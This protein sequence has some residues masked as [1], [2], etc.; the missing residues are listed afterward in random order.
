[1]IGRSNNGQPKSNGQPKRKVRY[2]VVGL[3]YFGQMAILPAFEHARKNSELAALISDDPAKLKR[4]GAKYG[5]EQ[6]GGY[7]EFE[8]CLQRAKVDAVYLAV[9]NSQHREFAVRA[10]RA[11]VHV[12]CEKPMAVTERECEE[13]I[14]ACERNRVKLMIG[15]RLHFE[16]GNLTA[17][18]LVRSGKLGDPRIFNS[19]FT[20]QVKD[21]HNIR[22]RRETGGGSVYDIGI[23]CINAAR[24]LFADEPVEVAAMTA[25][26]GEARF[27]EV[28]EMA[29]VLM[30][31]PN[32][33]LAN[34]V[35]SFGGAD[36]GSYEIVGTD[37]TLRM[38]PAYESA[39]D[40][41]Q[42]VTIKGR[43][44]ERTFPKRDQVAPE[45]IYFSDCI[46]NDQEPEPS[47]RE[48]LIDVQIIRAIYRSARRGKPVR[49]NLK[50]S[51]RYPDPSQEIH[52]L[53]IEKP[54]LIKAV[55]PGGK[56]E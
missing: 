38:D 50:K 11:K 43:R 29:S 25:N 32:D 52:R 53:P 44:R 51:D 40:L 24:Y 13:M 31:F 5:V 4:L 6:R 49:L 35:C 2:A 37:G 47:G 36:E 30:R 22:I 1:M 46:L 9:P 48:G 14:R 54:E 21:R 16:K 45:I 39:E 56:K 12:L 26:N 3:G 41:K 27:S 18:D 15:Y 10:A 19:V 23:Y 33:R 8:D 7:D 28:E 20:M 34:F 17:M 42:A 55:P